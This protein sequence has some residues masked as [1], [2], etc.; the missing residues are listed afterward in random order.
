VL[1]RSLGHG[2]FRVSSPSSYFVKE[3]WRKIPPKTLPRKSLGPGR[4][5]K[6]SLRHKQDAILKKLDIKTK[7]DLAYYWDL[8]YNC[9]AALGMGNGHREDINRCKDCL[10]GLL[11]PT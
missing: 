9:D 8:H 6:D 4:A 1:S 5:R 10:T 3:N 11:S 7:Y 2:C